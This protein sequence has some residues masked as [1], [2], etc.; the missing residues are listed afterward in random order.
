MSEGRPT[1]DPT[2]ERADVAAAVG[3]LP[4][5]GHV[6]AF[7]PT[8]RALRASIA[9]PALLRDLAPGVDL[10]RLATLLALTDPNAAHVLARRSELARSEQP[11]GPGAGWALVAFTCPARTSRFTD[12]S[13]GGWYAG[14]A[15][16]TAIAETAF[17]LERQLRQYGEPA[18]TVPFQVLSAEIAGA[19]V[20]LRQFPA[21]A[22]AAVHHRDDYSAAQQVAAIVRRRGDDGVTY[23]SVRHPGG[24]CLALFR[25]HVIHYPRPTHRV[26]HAW[27][28]T[29]L[30]PGVVCPA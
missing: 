19:F 24:T 5:T 26:D 23:D 17:H 1:D 30:H 3:A 27:T 25:P 10:D 6:A 28:G 11:E 7:A 2:D 29:E 9:V 4:A 18:Q 16:E 14:L 8:F 13:H 15:I 21:P 20:D 12:G 22:Y